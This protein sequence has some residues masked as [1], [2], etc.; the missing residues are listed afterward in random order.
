MTYQ[1]TGDDSN[2]VKKIYDFFKEL[3]YYRKL[4]YKNSVYEIINEIL[5]RTGFQYYVSALSNGKRRY[6]NIESLKEKAANYE[7]T[8]YRGLFNFVRYIEKIK[9]LDS[10]QGEASTV[11]E[12]DNIVRILSIHKSKGLQFPIVFICDTS[13]NFVADA[14]TVDISDSGYAAVDAIFPDVK[15]TVTP[16]YRKYVKDLNKQ[17]SRMEYLRLLY[18]ALTRAIRNLVW[19]KDLDS[20]VQ[21]CWGNFMEVIE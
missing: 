4:D 17:E 15:L 10:D 19:V 12:N 21:Q 16:T 14:G 6:L 18:V 11:N 5:E 7:K 2:L 8:S 13:S 9:E 1:E 3:N 20:T